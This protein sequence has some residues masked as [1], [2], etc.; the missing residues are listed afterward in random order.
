MALIIE[1]FTIIL[2]KYILSLLT[3]NTGKVNSVK[4]LYWFNVPFETL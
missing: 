1:H 4:K 2:G 3:N